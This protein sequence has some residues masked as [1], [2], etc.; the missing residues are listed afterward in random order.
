MPATVLN[1]A[2]T[3]PLVPAAVAAAEWT[4][5]KASAQALRAAQARQTSGRRRFVDPTTCE[6]EYTR[7][8]MEFLH[9]M[10]EYKQRSGR[11][12]PTWSEVLEVLKALGY[13]RRMLPGAIPLPP[14]QDRAASSTSV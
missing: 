9:A 13:E 8:E 11:M 1:Q 6:R 4:N 7:A 3:A 10:Q 12:F 14:V 5:R 2:V